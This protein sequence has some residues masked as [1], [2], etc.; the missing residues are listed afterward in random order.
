MGDAFPTRCVTD[1][2]SFLRVTR[3]NYPRHPRTRKNYQVWSNE[4]SSPKS[5]SPLTRPLAPLSS[6]PVL[7]QLSPPALRRP[8]SGHHLPASSTATASTLPPRHPIFLLRFHLPSSS[9]SPFPNHDGSMDGSG[10]E[11]A[12][13]R[14]S[15][16]HGPRTIW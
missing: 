6:S 16:G 1:N 15:A 2:R 4:D 13:R 9:T 10:E 11:A 12:R 3:F 14:A 8:G 7:S 5:R